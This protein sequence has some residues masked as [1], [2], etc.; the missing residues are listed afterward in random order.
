[1]Q[2]TDTYL[3]ALKEADH[4]KKIAAKCGVEIVN[5]SI[6][7]MVF[8]QYTIRFNR[9]SDLIQLGSL[10]VLEQLNQNKI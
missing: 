10:L 2:I 8:D 4:F 5:V 3:V 9:A 6:F 1:M 7:D